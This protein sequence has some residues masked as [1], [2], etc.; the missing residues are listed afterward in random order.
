MNDIKWK[1]NFIGGVWREGSSNTVQ[2]ICNPYTKEA[3]TS[4]KLADKQDIDEAYNAAQKAQHEWVK[5]PY[6]EKSRVIETAAKIILERQAE[7]VEL[8]V[9]ESGCTRLKANIEVGA[10]AGILKEAATYPNRMNGQILPSKI[11]GKEHRIYMNPVGVIGVITPWNFPF[12]LSM[13]SVGPALA[14]GNGVVLKPDPHTPITGGLL[15]AKIFED[16]GIPK[17]LL[18]VLAVDIAEVG[19]A[20]I[21]HPVPRVISFTGSTVVGRH[22][23]ETAGR[24]LKKTS[25]ELGGNNAFIVLDDANIENAVSAAVFGKFLHN[26]QICMAINRIIVD[27]KIYEPFVEMFANKVKSL[28]VGNPADEDT[29]IGA[30]INERQA[31]RI[32]RLINESVS[33][34]AKM[35]LEGEISG[36]I[37]YPS[38]LI[39]CR[40]NMAIAQN[41]IFG[42]VAAIIPVDSEEEAIQ[43]ANDCNQGLSGAVFSG[44]IQRGVNVAKQIYTGMIHVNDQS[45]NDEPNIAFGGEKESGLGRYNG[46]WVLKEFTTVKWISVQEKT[47]QYPF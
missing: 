46:E 17:G 47:R 20:F 28:K 30:L 4:I 25:L 18:S 9:A 38:I 35:L 10:A 3:I 37:V 1:S 23:A 39:D 12:T 34:G 26:G 8:L 15:I 45:V 33:Q 43:V 41:E 11:P 31:E 21:E 6:Y 22:I 7:I 29:V 27:R 19:D 14:T 44:D 40:N 42:P 24:H 16:A 36:N 5:V 2:T 32:K 13:R